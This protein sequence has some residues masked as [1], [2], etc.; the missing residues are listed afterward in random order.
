MPT[1]NKRFL[2]KLVLVVAVLTAA[3]FAVH[4]VQ[5]D[6]IPEALKRQAERAEDANKL[7]VAIH[8]YR[9]YLE[10][11]P[12]DIDVQIKLVDLMRKRNPTARGQA[13]V[14][15]LFDRI[16]RADPDRHAVRRDALAA[17]LKLGRYSDAV[18][19]AEALLK[20]YPSE[21]GL[22]QQLGAAQAGLNR[23]ADA[24]G[25]YQRALAND[26]GEILGYQRLAQLLWRNMNDVPAARD[27]LNQMVKAL[28]QNPDGHLIRARFEVFQADEP[29]SKRGDLKLAATNLQR[30]LE[31]DP[32]NAEA[33]MLLADLYQRE[34][35][36][37]AAHA[38]LRDAVALYPRDLRLVKSLS[39]L[40][41]SRGNTP[42]AIA[43]LED[44]LKATPDGF[45]LLVPLADLLVQQGDTA[46][47]AEI[48]QRLQA[49]K[50]PATQV[51]YLTA[52]IAMRDAKWNDAIGMLDALR[53]EVTNMPGLETQLNLL[54]A[55][56]ANK[57]ADPAAEEKAF[58]RVINAD[59]K[60]VQAR[61]GLSNLYLALGR[62][63][64][65]LREL[66]AA[67]QS[68]YAAG[69]VVSQ[70][71]R[72]K[73]HRLKMGGGS[74]DEWRK[75]ELVVTNS[76]SR[77]GPVSSEPVI[78]QAEIGL[79]LGKH[80][81]VILFLRREV[82][83]RPGDAR[84]WSVLAEVAANAHGTA[85]GLSIVDEAQASAGDG[86]EVRLARGKLYVAE[87]G[88]VR[89]L[90]SLAER[91]ESWPEAEQLRLL[92]GLVEL[93][94]YI[95][96]QAS[97]IQ[98][99]QRIASRRPGDAVVWSRVHDRALRIGDKATAA[100]ARTAL[101]KLEGE[102]G[103]NVVL[104]NAA[105]STESEAAKSIDRMIAVFGSNPTRADACLTLARLCHL[106]GK[107]A[108]SARLTERAFALE[109]TRFEA[110]KAWLVLLIRTNADERAK[111]LV[112]RL[113]F[114]PLWAGDPF[115]NMIAS[116]AS[117]VPVD[118]GSKLAHWARP[119][120]ERDPGGLGWL[121]EIASANKHFDPVPILEE[122]TRK[123]SASADDWLRL[124]LAHESSDLND[125]KGRLAPAAYVAAAAV[126][127]ETRA[128][129][130]FE[131]RLENAPEKRLF[132]QA[133]LALHLSRGMPQDAAKAL[134]KYLIDQDLS[135]A[136]SAWCRRNLAML[137]AVGGTPAD[138]Q[139]AME[140]I[141]DVADA[142]SSAEELRATASVLTTLARYLEGADRVAVLTRA[143]LALDSAY[144]AG[145]S[146]KDLYNL[147]QL[148]RA[149]GNRTESRKCL[150]ILLNAE[151]ENI[152]YL[153]A[154][155]EESV[156]NQELAQAKT[157]AEKL[158][159]HH[160]G[161]FRAIAAVARY[162][163]RAGSPENALAV[164]ERYSQNADPAAGDHLTR[165]GRV[166]ELLDELARLPNVRGTPAGHAIADAAVERYSSLVATRPEA[167]IG[168]VGILASDGRASVG[169]SRLERLG[170]FTPVRVKAAAGLAA[171][172]A[173]GVTE[174][175]AA[176]VLGWIDECLK[177]EPESPMLLMNRGEFLTMR[178]DLAGAAAEYEKV[179]AADARNV[180]A[181]NNLAW[182]LA[183]E[184]RTAERAMELVT[185][186]TR[187]V[188]L[189]GDLLDT[190]ARVRIT[191]KQYEQAERDL[192]D[193]I[194]L[195]PTALRWFHLAVSRLGQTPP[196]RDD[197]EKAFREAKRRG[198]DTRGIH[199]SDLPTFKVLDSNAK[200][201]G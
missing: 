170:Q 25:S 33:S 67:M 34:R 162:E 131:P 107:E 91:I 133:R 146:S 13:E 74:A 175:Q 98:T 35:N 191:L 113:A 1:I 51:K 130:N 134:E 75:L 93:F 69:S 53:R 142:S 196:K 37:P 59:P 125:A 138:R 155:L 11:T 174:Q 118:A 176:A 124:A 172:R 23:L 28:P 194:R 16:L 90:A 121:A 65:S 24:K 132:A 186:A 108:E 184:P 31:L 41:L 114:D 88:R 111:Q 99:L 55:V 163:C 137:Y 30:V 200:S 195:E 198:L 193:A 17:C 117:S 103:N 36:I 105:S 109:P 156:D 94:D 188:G 160:S 12:D 192:D 46:R 159:R 70:Y 60:N 7:D 122:A 39:W 178:Q 157:F 161:E 79:A 81:E 144:K 119:F 136:D 87:P 9:Q 85:A 72:A 181:L 199:P 71:V 77:F 62:F 95:G 141:K 52:R 106:A 135:K 56:C 32:E 2:L 115:R 102:T 153:V 182:I 183:A 43:V 201:G 50:A 44:G 15:F 86:P 22:W 126:L 187:E 167:I 128:G 120:V 82:G 143:A 139:R 40:E 149:A 116:V 76:A 92:Y 58:Q 150:Q 48:L 21:A 177:E 148:Y 66:E 6:R 78:L 14:I 96:D 49:R 112:T 179:I 20:S 123:R 19:H 97:V 10:F 185:R 166:A 169:F 47:T 89:P 83:R 104:C 180:V 110:A 101:V 57:V 26:P 145:K 80:S 61:V 45:E 100:Q 173:G 73:S 38:M 147:S 151:P 129:A 127:I 64:D 63:D 27:V 54:L 140:L 42:A 164:A 84:L 168:V 68:P 152:Y 8:Y 4:A 29:G 197:A 171:I 3:L 165:S 5:A 18:T 190:R 189:T 154:A 158:M